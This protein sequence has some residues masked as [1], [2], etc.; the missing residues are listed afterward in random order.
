M[1]FCP[2]QSGC[3]MIFSTRVNDFAKIVGRNVG[4][5]TNGDTGC[6]VYQK[7]WKTGRQYHR[8]FL[9]LIKVRDKVYSIFIDIS[10]HFHGNFAESG[11]CITHGSCAV[12]VYGTEVSMSVYQRIADMTSPAPYLPVLRKWSC[13]HGDGIYPW[14]RRRYGHIFCEACPDRCSAQSWS[15]AL[16]SA[17]ALIHPG[18]PEGHAG[19]MTLMA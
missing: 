6:S 2:L 19:A 8:L 17:P 5:H 13:L 9:R 3:R 16:V 4:C 7:I 10:K 14:Y 15:T 18:H 12:A 1:C 11:F